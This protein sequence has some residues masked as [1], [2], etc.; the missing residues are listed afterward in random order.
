L[1]ENAAVRAIL[2][3]LALLSIVAWAEPA[4]AYA[5]MIRHGYGG[6]VTCHADPSG[7]ELLTAYG[8]A[9]GD[10]ILRMRYGSDAVS[11]KA[12]SGGE[13]KSESFDQFDDF[14]E[15]GGGDSRIIES[16]SEPEATAADEA[17]VED[18][19]AQEAARPAKPPAQK[20]EAAEASETGPSST[21]GFLWGLFEP[22]ESLLLGGSYRHL[23]IWR[24]GELRTFPMQMDLYGQIR[25]GTF[26]AGGSL[27]AAKVPAG[28]PHARAA[29]VTTAQGDDWNL[30]SRTHW[31]GVDFGAQQE[32]TL[33]AGRLNLPFGVRIPEH[34][35]WVREATRTD[36]ESDQQHGAALAYSGR[37]LR[38]EAMVIAGNFQVNP[39]K[40]RERGYSAY[41]ETLV[42]EPFATGVS[43]LLTFSETDIETLEEQSTARG[44]HGL[45]TRVTVPPPLALLVEMNALH[46]SRRDL[47]YVG[48]LQLDYEAIQGLHLLATG[49]LLDGGFPRNP[50]V[51]TE[52]R[53]G[54]GEPRFGGWLSV[55]WFF[56]PHLEARVDLVVRGQ[57][58]TALLAQLHAYL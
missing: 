1:S 42:T 10:L 49:E 55:D 11:A 15:G 5:W 7:G 46:R 20:Q 31:L 3:T 16:Q 30:I 38:G 8:R 21:A 34:T 56:L 41:V 26:R 51:G 52:R 27:G 33:R 35:M 25:L 44:A 19:D 36:R 12:S 24:D 32:L 18:L 6:C 48:F 13:G 9:Q 47:G 54:F 17:D 45:F 53:P 22:P 43:S 29:Q 40:Y 37:V 14:D 58:E 4:S 23:T 28:S 50:P 2:A 57:E 39:A